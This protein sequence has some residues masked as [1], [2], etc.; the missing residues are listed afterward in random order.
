MAE[1]QRLVT[2]GTISGGSTAIQADVINLGSAVP[3]YVTLSTDYA[4][5]DPVGFPFRASFT[6]AV[7]GSL[8]FP[9][10]VPNGTRFAVLNCE[11][12]ALVAAGAAVLS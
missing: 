11:A 6:G 4:M 5:L 9:R 1:G 10:T 12:V 8:Q 2:V 3:V 7:A